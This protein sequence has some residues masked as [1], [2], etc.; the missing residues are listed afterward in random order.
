M[1]TI[2]HATAFAL[3]AAAGAPAQENATADEAAK[4]RVSCQLFASEEA[5][6]A[7]DWREGLSVRADQQRPLWEF[8]IRFDR[9]DVRPLPELDL[10]LRTRL[11]LPQNAVK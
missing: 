1:R 5:A 11:R 4:R 3:L 8:D 2:A 10:E 7:A 6:A 9:K